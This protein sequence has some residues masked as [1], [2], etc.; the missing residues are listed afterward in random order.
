MPFTQ[1]AVAD[2]LEAER[3]VA[4]TV[5]TELHCELEPS[6]VATYV[7]QSDLLDNVVRKDEW[8]ETAQPVFSRYWLHN[9]G[10]APLGYQPVSIHLR[11]EGERLRVSLASDRIGTDVEAHVRIVAPKGWDANPSDRPVRL[12]PNGWT[13]FHVTLI[14]PANAESGPHPIAAQID[15]NGQT[16]EDVLFVDAKGRPMPGP[17]AALLKVE[18]SNGVLLHNTAGFDIH[19]ELQVIS[20]WGTWDAIPQ[21]TFGFD[22]AAGQRLTVPIEV[23]EP[24]G[25]AW[26]LV[27]CMWFG[28]VSYSPAVPL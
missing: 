3:S 11:A 8:R 10:A 6:D 20:P 4:K 28:R 25:C 9:R 18:L 13:D 15:H 14:P 23:G 17:D 27:K 22:V 16:Y 2:L 26:Y 1:A 7:L 21:A 12:S 24:S 5:D 19:G